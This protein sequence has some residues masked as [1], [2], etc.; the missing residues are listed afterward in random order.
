MIILREMLK[1]ITII[2]LLYLS[3]G[4]FPYKATA[5]NKSW[6][7]E[8]CINYAFDNN[9]QLKQHKIIIEQNNNELYRSKLEYIPSFNAAYGHNLN[10]GRSVNLNDLQII[11]NMLSQSSSISVNAS[12]NIVDG[13]S[14]IYGTKINKKA[15]EISLQNEGK[16]KNEL[17]INITKAYLQILLSKEISKVAE[18]NFN[19]ISEQKDRT[20]ILVDGGK[21]AYS[22]LLDIEAQL[23]KERMQ[24]INAKNQLTLNTLIL[25][26]LLDLQSLSDFKIEEPNI[27]ENISLLEI[28]NIEQ[29][30]DISQNLPQI[31][32]ANLELEKNRLNL[33]LAKGKRYPSISFSAGYGTFY[34]SS[35]EGKYFGQLNDNRNP[36]LGFNLNIP[37]FNSYQV[38]TNIKNAKLNLKNSK[39]EL[40]NSQQN[41]FK[42]IQ[43]AVNDAY[44]FSEK[45]SASKINLIAVEESFKYVES[46]FNAGALTSTDYT[47]AKT[48]LLNAQSEFYQ[49]KYQFI[50]QLKIIDFYKGIPIQL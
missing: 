48:N 16:L 5:Q 13:L 37:I 33:L 28:Q 21:Q 42:D 25:A 1:K 47:V 34:S 4:S 39:L 45:L 46:K 44:A 31:Q 35:S 43:M 7:L 14:K 20:K 6:T 26:Q 30:Y 32:K 29:M 18:S 49:S 27:D 36:S 40:K 3:I 10:W 12:I 22:S 11:N 8:D 19:S 24:L 2:I 23:A 50:F 38:V 15:L 9:I 41:L 17:S